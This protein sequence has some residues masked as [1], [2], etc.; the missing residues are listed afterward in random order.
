MG[1]NTRA[2]GVVPGTIVADA[3]PEGRP[4]N[5]YCS[6]CRSKLNVR[7]TTDGDGGT[8]DLV[9][10]C[11]TCVARPS[12]FVVREPGPK[13]PASAAAIKAGAKPDKPRYRKRIGHCRDCDRDFEHQKPG[14]LP[15][16]CPSCRGVPA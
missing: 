9:D 1:R 11:P 13:P 14:P 16:R 7:I 12:R 10:P 4:Q 2:P 15:V 3:F 5:V 6:R 8:I